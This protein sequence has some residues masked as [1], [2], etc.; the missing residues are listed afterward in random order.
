[1]KRKTLA[2]ELGKQ[3]QQDLRK[4][5]IDLSLKIK[6]NQLL[7]KDP[8]QMEAAC[9]TPEEVQEEIDDLKGQRFEILE[10]IK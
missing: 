10:I 1:M 8:F 4:E 5:I 7:L 9:T 2:V 6:A 3:Y